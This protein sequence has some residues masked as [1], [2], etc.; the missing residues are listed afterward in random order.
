MYRCFFKRFFDILFSL[1][2]II[3]LSPIL[4]ILA[5]AIKLDSKG[6]VIFKQQRIGKKGKVFNIYK[7]RS[8][9]VGAEKTGSGVYSNKSDTRVTKVG[10]F[11]RATSLDELPQFFNVLFG[12]MSFIGPRPPLTYHPWTYDKYTKEQLKMF[13]VRPGITGW[14]QVNGRREVEWNK[15]IRLNVYYVE[16]VSLLLDLKIIFMTIGKVFA[17]ANNENKGA[18]VVDNKNLELMYITNNPTVAKVADEAGVDYIFVDME[19]IGKEDRQ[20]GNTVKN[21][22]DVL[23]VK[24]VK[25]AVKNSKVLVRCNSI[26]DATDEYL[27]TEDEIESVIKAGAD[28]IMLPYFKTAMEVQR[29]ISAVDGRVKTIL[30]LETPEAVENLDQILAIDGIDKIHIGL[31][32]LSLGYKQD[33]MFE[34][35][36]DGTVDKIISK[37]KEKGVPY[38][39]GGIASL[40]KGL[41]PAEMV[42]KEH[43]RL[44]SSMAILSRSF[45]NTQLLH[46]VSEIKRAFTDGINKIR[47]FEKDCQ[48]GKFD[49]EENKKQ[50]KIVVDEVVKKLKEQKQP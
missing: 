34:P 4:L 42:I 13:D 45:C 7:F 22:H 11:L 17:G 3:V 9:C 41:V 44:G 35:L 33:F 6:P 40:G 23:D 31:N 20:K 38:G 16:N 21:H 30:L 49:L 47:A 29:F 46:E 26:H 2:G 19:Y 43:Y 1:L 15:R 5:V 36:V 39:F 18:T 12:H 25:S 32:D 37:I 24:N 10:K 8:M 50:I 28:Y 27:S 48:D 14:A